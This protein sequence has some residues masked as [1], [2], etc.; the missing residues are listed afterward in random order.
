MITHNVKREELR[1]EERTI[2]RLTINITSKDLEE[3]DWYIT[4]TVALGC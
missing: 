3:L 1:K 2:K 4:E